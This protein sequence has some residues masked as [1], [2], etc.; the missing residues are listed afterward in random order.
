M[1]KVILK[2]GIMSIPQMLMFIVILGIGRKNINHFVGRLGLE[3]LGKKFRIKP[4]VTKQDLL[5]IGICSD[6]TFDL[7]LSGAEFEVDDIMADREKKRNL[8]FIDKKTKYLWVYE[9]MIE[10]KEVENENN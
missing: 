4:E 1:R 10:Y 5:D 6:S 7:L 9:D 2:L 3:K 8:V